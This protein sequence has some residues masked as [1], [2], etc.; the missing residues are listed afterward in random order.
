MAGGCPR[1]WQDV[2]RRDVMETA[3]VR[4]GK[5][6]EIKDGGQLSPTMA[7]RC[8]Q[9]RHG[10]S[11]CAHGRGHGKHMARSCCAE[12]SWR[13]RMCARERARKAYGREPLRRDVMETA[14]VRTEKVTESIWNGAA[15]LRR[16]GDSGCAHGKGLGGIYTMRE[17]EEYEL[18]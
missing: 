4:T 14:A 6:T 5:D 16:H 11:G 17:T 12:T 9:R 3:A 7:G 1:Q 10:D 2:V 15:A 13:L 18:E 8:A